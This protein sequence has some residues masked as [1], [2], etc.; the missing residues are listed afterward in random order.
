VFKVDEEFI[1][2][3]CKPRLF[4]IVLFSA[5]FFSFSL[6]AREVSAT[7]YNAT[8]AQTG[9]TNGPTASGV[10]PRP[11]VTVAIQPA[12]ERTYPLWTVVAFNY[13]T[14]KNQPRSCGIKYVQ[15]AYLPSEYGMILDYKATNAGGN[16]DFLMPTHAYVRMPDGKKINPAPAFGRCRGITMRKVLTLK[17]HDPAAVPKTQAAL[18]VL[19]RRHVLKNQISQNFSGRR[20]RASLI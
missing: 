12:L 8:V 9:R 17:T 14:V 11:G 6:Q 2:R 4:G 19:V 16:I 18:A 20:L 10:P 13:S 3:T 15:G 5:L 1:M 7:A